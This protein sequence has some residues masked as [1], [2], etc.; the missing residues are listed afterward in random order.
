MP[1]S[2]NSMTGFARSEGGTDLSELGSWVWTWELKSVNAKG[3][4][5]RSRLPSL[6]EDWEADVRSRVQARLTRGSVSVMWTLRRQDDAETPDLTVNE[7]FLRKVLDLQAK[8][9]VEGLVMPTAPTLDRLLAVKGVVELSDRTPD[10]KLMTAL[11]PTALTDLDRAIADLVSA[12]GEEGRRLVDA[13]T[14]HLDEIADLL[15]QAKASAE[16]QPDALR[17]RMQINWTPCCNRSLRC[18]KSVLPRNSPC[19]PLKPTYA[20]KPIVS[21]PTLSSVEAFWRAA[22]R[23]AESSISCA[24]S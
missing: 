7:A 10:A 14:V 1:A 2:A 20:R 13:L 3:L 17:S 24:R 22:D 11:K 23:S 16:C 9:E 5:V 18:P 4:D 8:L 15:T 6:V 19:S 21:R 12:Q